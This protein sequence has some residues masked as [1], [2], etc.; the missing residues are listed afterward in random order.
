MAEVVKCGF[1][2]DPEILTLVE[3]DP[4]AALDPA[5]PVLRRADPTRPSR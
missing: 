4:A 5:G 3:A 1:I 2:A